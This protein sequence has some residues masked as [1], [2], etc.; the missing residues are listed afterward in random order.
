MVIN[1]SNKSSINNDITVYFIVV[2]YPWKW[3]LISFSNMYCFVLYGRAV[4]SVNVGLCALKLMSCW[5]DYV[6]ENFDRSINITICFSLWYWRILVLIY[7]WWISHLTIFYIYRYTNRWQIGLSISYCCLM[8]I[9][10]F[11][12]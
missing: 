7:P 2:D 3:I 10:I 5:K 9:N 1:H 11:C 12:L 6:P 8:F 4:W